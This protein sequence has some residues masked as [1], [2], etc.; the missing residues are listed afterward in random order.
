MAIPGPHS[1]DLPGRPITGVTVLAGARAAREVF[2]RRLSP[3]LTGGEMSLPRPSCQRACKSGAKRCQSIFPVSGPG[4]SLGILLL[5]S[6]IGCLGST[7]E[8]LAR[9]RVH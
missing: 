1:L 5:T 4:Q 2:T 9:T 8:T 6:L 3:P 7:V